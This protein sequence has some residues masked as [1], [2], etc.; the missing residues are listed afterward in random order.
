MSMVCKIAGHKF[1]DTFV[2]TQEGDFYE[3]EDARYCRQ[4]GLVHAKA[5]AS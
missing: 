2:I 5:L 1:Q 3:V 4:C